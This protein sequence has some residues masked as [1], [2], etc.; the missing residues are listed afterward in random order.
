MGRFE[1]GGWGMESRGLRLDTGVW[2]L[3]DKVWVM[4]VGVRIFQAG[5]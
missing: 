1:A 5:G 2:W 3:D 4:E